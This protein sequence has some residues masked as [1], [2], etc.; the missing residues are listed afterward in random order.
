MI[1]TLPSL[2][3]VLLGPLAGVMADRWGRRR[4]QLWA[5]ALFALAGMAPMV[6]D[7]LRWILCAQAILGVAE[8][9]L[10]GRRSAEM[11]AASTH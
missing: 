3:I 4:L 9:V 11:Q 10:H 7:D 5:L 2:G 1:I 6:L 8:A